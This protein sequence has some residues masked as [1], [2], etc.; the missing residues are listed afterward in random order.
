MKFDSP[1]RICLLTLGA[2]YFT[3]GTGSLAVVGL[4]APMS[5]Q[6][7]VAPTQIAQ[8]VTVFALTF[9]ISA[10]LMQV[11]LGGFARRS[12]LLAGLGILAA[13]SLASAL[14]PTFAWAVAARILMALGASI[15]GP[16]ASAIATTIVKPAQQ[17]KAL[18]TVFGGMT[19]ATVLGVPLSSWVGNHWSWQAVFV[20][21]AVVAIVAAAAIARLIDDR[22]TS[23]RVTFASFAGVFERASTGWGVA[24]T[25]FHMAAQFA[26]YALVAMILQERFHFSASWIAPSL[27]AFGVGGITGNVLAGRFADRFGAVRV[28]AASLAGMMFAFVAIAFL[29]VHPAIV[30]P[31][32]AFWSGIAFLFMAPQQKRLIELAPQQRGL[33]LAVNAS[34][35]Y[36]GMSL[37]TIVGTRVYHAW[38]IE[39]V[40]IASCAIVVL[41]MASL[42]MSMRSKRTPMG[43]DPIYR[44]LKDGV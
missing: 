7:D 16:V 44:L 1:T 29:P 4:L 41:A 35:I 25:L 26:S 38:G 30:L 9:A 27:F 23:A 17:A 31:F 39:A 36:L 33:L 22:T 15:V 3:V 32:M 13:G 28:M 5:T 12:M 6:L 21:L 42:A 20:G 18:A 14:A 10:P 19:I 37:G 2:G 40:N 34:A 11:A 43:S 24:T 8:L